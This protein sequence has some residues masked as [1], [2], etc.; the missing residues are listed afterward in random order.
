MVIDD[1]GSVEGISA[2]I[3]CTKCRSGRV[4]RMPDRQPWKIGLLSQRI[5]DGPDEH[6]SNLI[7]QK[8]ST[9][10][11]NSTVT[12]MGNSMVLGDLQL[13]GDDKH[14]VVETAFA[15]C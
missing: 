14:R 10:I 5:M 1:T 3:H 6:L 12:G 4:S 2:F 9:N 13:C 7:R 11:K 8:D 15:P